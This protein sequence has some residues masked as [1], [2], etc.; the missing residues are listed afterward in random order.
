M[1]AIVCHG[2]GKKDWQELPDPRIT[3][4]TDAIRVEA[5]TICGT[6]LHI[7]AGDVPQTPEGR[8]LG[9]EAVGTVVATGS[10]VTTRPGA[11]LCSPASSTCP[12][13]S[14]TGSAWRTSSMPTKSSPTPP[15]R[16]R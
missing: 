10:A 2:A 14:P 12:P 7:L 6:D 4:P 8:V 16:V 5:V 9:H 1:R 13:S 11:R 3:D 15:G